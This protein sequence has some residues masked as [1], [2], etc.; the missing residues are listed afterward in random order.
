MSFCLS[1]RCQKRLADV[2]PQLVAVVYRAAWSS[3]VSFIVTEGLR[4]AERQEECV[5]T[6]LSKTM[7]SFHLKQSSGFSHAVDL[8]PVIPTDAA[9]KDWAIADRPDD[10]TK[11]VKVPWNEWGAFTAMADALKEAAKELKVDL[12]WGGDWA[13]LRDGPHFQIPR[14]ERD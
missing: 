4:T 3:P 1:T 6:G 13:K 14:P 11:A 8:A 9:D 2:H 12:T 7:D 10:T 5:T